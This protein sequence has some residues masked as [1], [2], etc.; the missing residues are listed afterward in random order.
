MNQK[1]LVILDH[2]YNSEDRY[3]EFKKRINDVYGDNYELVFKLFKPVQEHYEYIPQNIQ[4]AI[5][6]DTVMTCTDD[7]V[8]VIVDGPAAYF[9]LQTFYSGNLIAINPV[10]DI[11]SEYPYNEVD[12][13][14]L[15]FSRSFQTNNIVCLLSNEMKSH[16]EEYGNAFYD[17]TVII[18]KENLHDIHS[19]W[20]I[21]SSFDQVFR[22]MVDQN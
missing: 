11:Y 10:I 1:I 5:D 17:T 20:S 21:G 14:D 16:R 15:K 6:A 8:C 18:A 19:F 13:K 4:S 7:F 3:A 22:Y 2:N 9:W 12:S